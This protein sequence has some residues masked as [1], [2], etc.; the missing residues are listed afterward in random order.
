MGKRADEFFNRLADI[1]K[2]KPVTIMTAGEGARTLNGASFNRQLAIAA[3]ES[4]DT[5]IV[6]DDE[7]DQA[8]ELAEEGTDLIKI[9]LD[10]LDTY[11]KAMNKIIASNPGIID[12]SGVFKRNPMVK[13][14]IFPALD[15]LKYA[16]EDETNPIFESINK[17]VSLISNGATAKKLKGTGQSP[18]LYE[19][20]Q[21]VLMET[22]YHLVNMIPVSINKGVSMNDLGTVTNTKVLESYISMITDI[23]SP[24]FYSTLSN[25]IEFE[26]TPVAAGVQVGAESGFINTSGLADTPYAK[27]PEFDVY[28]GGESILNAINFKKSGS[29]DIILS[30]LDACTLTAQMLADKSLKNR[31]DSVKLVS[32]LMNDSNADSRNRTIDE[33]V[34][35]YRANLLDDIAKRKALQE[36]QELNTIEVMF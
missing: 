30:V 17:V 15:A 9:T 21:L 19:G 25:K 2:V 24:E 1:K 4:I 12:Q 3:G 10:S 35:K 36:K 14:M 31:Y 22:L 26:E 13:D 18:F 34:T 29:L 33:V 6:R 23:A 28:A 7:I 5:S 8:T 16:Y 20:L 32:T 27:Y 11:Y